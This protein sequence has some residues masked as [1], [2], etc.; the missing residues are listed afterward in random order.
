MN[1]TTAHLRVRFP[2]ELRQKLGTAAEQNGRSLNAELI[3]RLQTSFADQ[4]A[5]SLKLFGNERLYMLGKRLAQACALVEFARGKSMADDA[6]T[7]AMALAAVRRAIDLYRCP[8]GEL[9]LPAD[10]IERRGQDI[11]RVA[12][13]SS[14]AD[15]DALVR[16]PASNTWGQMVLKMIAVAG[17]RLD[18]A[19]S[20]HVELNGG[21]DNE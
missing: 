13:N 1:T 14:E 19:G 21:E 9:D 2:A 15:I 3:A 10:E 18:E 20:V 4:E 17:G 11:G 8:A 6:T 16:D 12:V 7:C 5:A